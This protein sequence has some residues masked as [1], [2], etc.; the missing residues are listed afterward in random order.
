M[1]GLARL[2]C[3]QHGAVGLVVAVALHLGACASGTTGV[4]E[5]CGDG[6]IT[7]TEECDDANVSAGDGCDELCAVEAGYV[8]DTEGDMACYPIC[9]DGLVLGTELCDG[10]DLKGSTCETLNLGTGVLTCDSACQLDP[11]GCTV[12]SCGN[13]QL[14]EGELCDGPLV[15]DET[16][17][18]QG[19]DGGALACTAACALDTSGCTLASCG[20]GIVEGVEECDDAGNDAGDGCS[21]NCS[22]EEG[23]VCVGQPS[24]CALLCGNGALDTSEQCDGANLGGQTCESLG[25][26]YVGGNLGCLPG[27]TFDTGQCD[28]P[29]CGNSVLDTGE[30]CD[31]ILLN[32]Q[33]CESVGNYIGGTL[34]CSGSCAFDLSNCIPIACGDGII[35]TGEVCDDNNNTSGDG[36]NILCNVESGWSCT[37]GSPSVCTLL[38]GNNQLD[39]GEDCDGAQLGTSTC[40]SLGYD[41]GSLACDSGC[42]FDT[43]SCTMF[44]CGDGQVTGIEDCD[45][46]NL[47]STTCLSLG[48][49][50]GALS[51]T[52]NCGFDTGS[53]IAPVCGDGVISTGVGEQCDDN[54]N[55]SGDGCSGLCQV[56]VGWVCQ[57]EPSQCTPSC[58]NSNLDPGEDCD[59]SNL[60][61]ATCSSQGFAGGPLSCTNCAFDTSSCLA[62]VCPNGVREGTEECDGSDFGGQDCTSFGYATGTLSCSGGC[63]IETT[64]CSM[65]PAT[66]TSVFAD[67]FSTPSSSSWTTGSD[68]AVSSSRWSAYTV[69]NHG[70]RIYNGLLEITNDESSYPVHGQGYA[71]VKT[72]GTG[73]EYDNALYDPTLKNNSGLEIVWSFNMRRNDPESTDGGFSCSSSSSQNDRTV[74]LAYVLATSSAAGLNASTST[75][76]PSATAYGYA[77]VMGGASGSVRLV[78]FTS[79]LRNGAITDIVSSGGFDPDRYFSVRVSYNAN[80]DGWQLEARSDGSSSFA[81]PAAGSYGFAGT[82][83]DSTHVNALLEYSGPYFQ[84]G[85]TGMCSSTYT[86][87][88]DNVQVGVRCAP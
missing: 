47:N 79:G 77:V 31:G 30:Q 87:H 41:T 38:C 78:R 74:G 37:Q 84:T 57:S 34:L 35:S 39:S 26:G 10:T 19:Y 65:C 25:L 50:G 67:D 40:Q 46:A 12:Y 55:T 15:G 70:V 28:L 63:T 62:T 88:F 85:C 56:E 81:D 36:C 23:W 17:Q 2:A 21:S 9:G 14:D 73:S 11:G 76:N 69:P 4:V 66:L 8:C 7:E 58:G 72:G 32:N 82:G 6:L 48:F 64:G 54:N 20:N 44:S 18:D 3:K 86:T 1:S 60:N 83:T 33:T 42:A 51:C 13:G 53:C 61:G 45:G 59:G 27:C 43:S 49:L 52:A 24:V 71:T 68:A 29:T 16:C 75:C 80:T 5:V 22:V